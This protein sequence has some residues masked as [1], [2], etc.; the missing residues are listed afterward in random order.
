ML[1]TRWQA[2]AR[3]LRALDGMMRQPVERDAGAT[4]CR[5]GLQ[6]PRGLNDV[7][8]RLPG[9]RTAWPG[10]ARADSK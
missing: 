10:A 2:R 4:T 7:G 3:R 1:A 9:H 6:R 8:F 5:G